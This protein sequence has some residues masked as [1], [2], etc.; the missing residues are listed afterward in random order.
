M[1]ASELLGRAIDEVAADQYCGYYLCDDRW[2]PR[3]SW[4]R[5]GDL[6]LGEVRIRLRAAYVVDVIGV[7]VISRTD[8]EIALS[9]SGRRAAIC[10]PL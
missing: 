10:R 3:T 4:V 2:I 5:E 6:G 8:A 9:G 1:F 7:T